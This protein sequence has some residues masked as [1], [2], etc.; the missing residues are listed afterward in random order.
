MAMS[1][2]K[3]HHSPGIPDTGN[4]ARMFEENPQLLNAR[5]V[6]ALEQGGNTLVFGTDGFRPSLKKRTHPG[7]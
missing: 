1:L 4:E 7:A 6:Q 5:L 2:A 3:Q